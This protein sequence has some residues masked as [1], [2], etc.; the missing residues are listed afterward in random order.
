MP[1]VSEHFKDDDDL[2]DC[3]DYDE[4][5]VV[6]GDSGDHVGLIQQALIK[7]GEG[8]INA[9]ELSQM[10]YGATT[11]NSVLGYKTRRQI[12]N[13]RYQQAP[14]NIVGKM[15]IERLDQDMVEFEK[16]QFS[17]YVSRTRNGDFHFHFLCPRL[18]AG[19]HEATPVNPQRWGYMV[20]IYGDGETDY[21]GYKDYAIDPDYVMNGKGRMPFTWED[22]SRG[23]VP[24]K[25]ASDIFMR[26][27]PVYDDDD[28]RRERIKPVSTVHEITRIAA[29]G[30]RLTYAGPSGNIGQ[31]GHKIL[32][33]GS[34]METNYVDA[35]GNLMPLGTPISKASMIVYILTILG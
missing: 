1:L 30:C 6:F 3:L 26:S 20:N 22:P 11:A 35:G 17:Q 15:T 28:L 13:K 23:G 34:L 25:K 24:D 9:R 18:E 12:I 33:L 31:F 8:V 16:K 10:F 4:D 32:R 19:L 14:D 7:L 27:S 29:P 2:Q 5:H 21:L